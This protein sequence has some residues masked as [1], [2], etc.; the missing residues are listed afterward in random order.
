MIDEFFRQSWAFISSSSGFMAPWT[1]EN[2]VYYP[3]AY[4]KYMKAAYL[5]Y[6][7]ANK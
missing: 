2:V 3:V 5:D 7:E 6:R 4:F 1:W